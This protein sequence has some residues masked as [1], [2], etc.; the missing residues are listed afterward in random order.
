MR[1]KRKDTGTSGI[2]ITYGCQKEEDR[3]IIRWNETPRGNRAG[4]TE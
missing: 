1:D 2:G 3:Q 4:I